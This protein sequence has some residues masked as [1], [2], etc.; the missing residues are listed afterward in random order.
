M[1]ITIKDTE[2]E[3]KYTIRALFIYEQLAD[4]TFNPQTLTEL[5]LFF[6]AL[7]LACKTDI[8]L[9]FNELIEICDEDS[10]L[11][12]LFQSWLNDEFTKQNQFTDKSKKKATKKQ[13]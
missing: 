8:Q 11:F 10:S 9:T 5:F 13:E 12:P 2:I 6:Y 3:I 7:I 1:K 4:K